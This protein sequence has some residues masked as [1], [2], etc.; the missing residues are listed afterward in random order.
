MKEITLRFFT[1]LGILYLV[2][3]FIK[4]FDL[5]TVGAYIFLAILL[6]IT[7]VVIEPIIKFFTLP[8]NLVTFGIFNFIIACIYL[9][10]FNLF[11]PGFN[12]ADGSIGPIVSDTIQ[13]P[14]INM[15][16]IAIIIF[17]SILLTLLNNFVTWTQGGKKR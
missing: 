10:F 4:G 9:Y 16:L 14:E 8:L 11:I 15:S 7:H 3:S 12:L 13:I 6:A 2:D 1:Y 5:T 17:S